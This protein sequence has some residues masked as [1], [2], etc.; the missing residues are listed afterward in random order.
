MITIPM[1][2]SV[3]GETLPMCVVMTNETVNMTIGAEYVISGVASFDGPYEYTPA[4]QE[5]TIA[6]KNLRAT[7]D[8]IINSIPS[9]YGLITWNGSELT[10]S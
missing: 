8:I 7:Q 1:N 9:N 3:Q 6:I 2:V 4:E 5:Q 10:V